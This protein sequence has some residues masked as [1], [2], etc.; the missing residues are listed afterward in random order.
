MPLLPVRREIFQMGKTQ[1]R[2]VAYF[3]IHQAER[4]FKFDNLS[5]FR[6]FSVTHQADL[7]TE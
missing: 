3:S 4:C 7:D 5:I 6:G 1:L 2:F